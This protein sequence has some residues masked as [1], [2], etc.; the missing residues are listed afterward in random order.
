MEA[1]SEWTLSSG[2]KPSTKQMVNFEQFE[3]KDTD[4]FKLCI[5]VTFSRQ[6]FQQLNSNTIILYF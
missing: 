1:Y 2:E 3:F 5:K 4:F 6:Y